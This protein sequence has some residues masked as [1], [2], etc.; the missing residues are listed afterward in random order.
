MQDLQFARNERARQAAAK[1]EEI[2]DNTGR[3]SDKEFIDFL[4]TKNMEDLEQFAKLTPPARRRVEAAP[5][6][7]FFGQG[8]VPGSKKG[9]LKPLPL[10]SEYEEEMAA[11]SK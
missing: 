5:V 7:N 6:A 9:S 2:I 4:K 10:N 3:E 11:A 1:I 8:V